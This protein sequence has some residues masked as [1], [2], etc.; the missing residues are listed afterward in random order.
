[1]YTSKDASYIQARAIK[2]GTHKLHPFYQKI[3]DWA[4]QKFGVCVLDFMCYT[5]QTSV[6]YKQQAVIL[7]VETIADC[8]RLENPEIRSF[9]DQIF[10]CIL[11]SPEW[12]AQEHDVIKKDF[13]STDIVPYPELFVAFHSLEGV[14]VSN[15]KK[16]VGERMEILGAN[17]PDLIWNIT[18]MS[19]YEFP[20]VFFYTDEALNKAH[21][22]GTVKAI[23][24]IY[25]Q[26]LKKHDEFNYFGEHSVSLR[27][28]SKE[29]FDRD[30]S[31]NWHYYF[32]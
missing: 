22:D 2:T 10:L 16:K 8:Q 15:A 14:E 6:G 18:G 4:N 20:I 26:E 21:Q 13:W 25:L 11:T 3:V 9:L 31:G 1:M 27:F 5:K 7:N 23:E 19:G 28:D 30:F 29:S 12:A 32:Q 24:K 17:Y